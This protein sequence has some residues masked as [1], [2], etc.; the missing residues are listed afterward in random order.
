[1]AS[2]ICR[3]RSIIAILKELAK[4]Q[5][6]DQ[7]IVL[8][9]VDWNSATGRT[10]QS[11]RCLAM[12]IG[13]VFGYILILRHLLHHVHSCLLLNIQVITVAL[14]PTSIINWM[15]EKIGYTLPYLN[16][17]VLQV[18]ISSSK[19]INRR[20]LRVDHQHYPVISDSH[21]LYY[22]WKLMFKENV[23]DT[24]AF[25]VWGK[26]SEISLQ[27]FCIQRK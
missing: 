7:V 27:Y 21:S 5:L 12:D 22:R 11:S 26:V 9:E 15:Q 4:V 16:C 23:L 24:S 1:M 17:L 10:T 2:V 25:F 18:A 3:V 20:F 8:A 19:C 14:K 13:F 6:A